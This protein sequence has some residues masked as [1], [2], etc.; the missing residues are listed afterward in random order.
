MHRG[1][2]QSLFEAV[3]GR[4]VFQCRHRDYMDALRQRVASSRHVIT[5]ARAPHRCRHQPKSNLPLHG[6]NFSASFTAFQAGNR[7]LSAAPQNHQLPGC[8]PSAYGFD[9]WTM[10]SPAAL[11]LLGPTPHSSTIANPACWQAAAMFS[12]FASS[13]SF[14]HAENVT[15]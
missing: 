1:G 7:I 5:A 13:S 15:P 12:L 4:L 2:C 10:V 14:A 9:N 6:T 3:A 11:R 8:S